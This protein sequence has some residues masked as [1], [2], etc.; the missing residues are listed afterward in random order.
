MRPV[1]ELPLLLLAALLEV[2][3]DALVR[4]GLKTQGIVA[5]LAGVAVLAAYG[6]MVN[7]TRLDFGRLMGIYIA[8]FLVVAQAVA[9]VAFKE[10]VR[11]PLI[12]GGGLVVAGG[13]I[14]T[15]W[16]G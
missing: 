4:H 9:V 3:G 6:I 15:V 2:G 13:V 14:M 1:R 12:V 8:L 5:M 10:R 11:L 7:L 16:R